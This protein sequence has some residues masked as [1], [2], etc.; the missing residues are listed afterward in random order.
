MFF[1]LCDLHIDSLAERNVAQTKT[2][3]ISQAVISHHSSQDNKNELVSPPSIVLKF[4]PEIYPQTHCWFTRE[5][6]WS[7][8]FQYFRRVESNKTT[9]LFAWHS[10]S[11]LGFEVLN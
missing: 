1:S 3:I 7:C 5:L 10:S 2:Q 9:L 8:D 4:H 11:R 6:A